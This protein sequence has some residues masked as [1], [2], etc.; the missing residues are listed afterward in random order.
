MLEI[1]GR[2]GLQVGRLSTGRGCGR[3]LPGRR[4]R[5]LPARRRRRS[6]PAPGRPCPRSSRSSRRPA[7]SILRRASERRCRTAC[8]RSCA[9][10]ASGP[11]TVR[12]LHAELGITSVDALRGRRG[13]CAASPQGPLGADRGEHPRGDHA[14]EQKSR[15]MLLH[16]A[17]ALMAGLLGAAGRRRGVVRSAPPGPCDGVAR[18]SA[19]STCWRRPT[20][21]PRSSRRSMCCRTWHVVSAGTDKS[22]IVLVDGPQV[23]LMV[24]PPAAWGTHLVHFT[25]S[26]EHNVA[27]RGPRARPRPVPLG[28]GLQGGRDRRAPHR[29]DRGGGLRAARPRLGPARAARGRR[30][31][32]GRRAGQLPD[33]VTI[34]DLRGDTHVHC[35]WTDGV[36]SIEAMARAARDLGR[37]WMV[38]TDHSPSLGSPAALDLERVEAQRE[39]IAR[40]NTSLAPFR[41]L[42]GTELEI[43]ADASPDYPDDVLAALRR[44]ARQHPHRPQ[45]VDRAAHR[46]R[47]GRHRASARRRPRPSPGRIVSRRDP[48]PLDWPRVFAA[49]ARTGRCSR[50]TA[51]R[52]STSTTH[53]PARRAGGRCA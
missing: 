6:C 26:K 4:R 39:E 53:W 33:L 44:R 1:L 11:R 32:P 47:A 50:S 19:T 22:S 51:A 36:D 15:R 12:L 25:G 27:L 34:A 24:C 42:H 21:R 23:D 38:L 48:L 28:E 45:P 29:C 40:L 46:P 9:S 3:A 14:I 13:G 41:I 17:D 49:A 37:A 10:R 35:D 52:A 5:A 30:R 7:S 18:R 43:R 31:D 20:T 8:S 16:D 2:G